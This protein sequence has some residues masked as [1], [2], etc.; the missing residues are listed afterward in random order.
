MLL[1]LYIVI[2]W[3]LSTGLR[4]KQNCENDLPH[5]TQLLSGRTERSWPEK[6]FSSLNM[7]QN[8]QEG[9][10]KCKFP[11]LTSRECRNLHSLFTPQEILILLLQGPDHL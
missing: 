10:Q 1:L 8:Y 9:L 7:Y 11:D 5:T 6:C 3:P 4:V 2:I